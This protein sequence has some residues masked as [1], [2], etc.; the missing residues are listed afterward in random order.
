MSSYS[1]K[2]TADRRAAILEVLAAARAP[3]N[4]AMLRTALEEVTLHRVGMDRVRAD[5]RW[6]AERGLV[7][8]EA[9]GMAISEVT[10]TERGEDV[11]HGREQVFGVAPRGKE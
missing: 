1:R 10:I 2:Y 9:E 5:V 11:A 3:A 6:L 7:V 4:V 8:E